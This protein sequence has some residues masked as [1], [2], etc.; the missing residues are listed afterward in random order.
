MK[1]DLKKGGAGRGNWGPE[2]DFDIKNFRAEAL[3]DQD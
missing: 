2:L 1:G 3:A